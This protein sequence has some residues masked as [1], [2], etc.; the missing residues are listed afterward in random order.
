MAQKAVLHSGQKP[1]SFAMCNQ[2][3]IE[4][5][6][7]AERLCIAVVGIIMCRSPNLTA[8]VLVVGCV[9]NTY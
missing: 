1:L 3:H 4:P 9:I 5:A 2:E 6:K 8:T 7:P